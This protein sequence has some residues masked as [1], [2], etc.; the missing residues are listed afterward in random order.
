MDEVVDGTLSTQGKAMLEMDALNGE[1]YTYPSSKEKGILSTSFRIEPAGSLLLYC[2]DKN[3]K[4]I[5][6]APEKTGEAAPG[7]GKQAGP[8]SAVY[9]TML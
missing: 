5:R 4:L 3:L 6:N 8:P 7:D 1:I 9:A 2:S